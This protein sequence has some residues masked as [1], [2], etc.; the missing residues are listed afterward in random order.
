MR[1]SQENRVTYI[2]T[3]FSPNIVR[4]RMRWT[5][6]VA[7]KGREMRTKVSSDNLYGKCIDN[8]IKTDFRELDFEGLEW[9]LRPAVIRSSQMPMWMLKLSHPCV[10]RDHLVLREQPPHYRLSY[11]IRFVLV[12]ISCL[13]SV[14]V[15]SAPSLDNCASISSLILSLGSYLE[16][17]SLPR[18]KDH[19]SS[20]YSRSW[21]RDG[22]V[23]LASALSSWLM[24]CSIGTVRP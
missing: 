5:G 23:P 17:L 12:A 3:A 22:V 9:I 18:A 21:P 14:S 7:R 19:A 11:D 10:L 8:D 4:I 20:W 24:R 2:I 15:N 13:H 6:H 1:T 16:L